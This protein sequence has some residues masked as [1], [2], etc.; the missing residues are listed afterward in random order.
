MI[1]NNFIVSTSFNIDLYMQIICITCSDGLY[2]LLIQE[3]FSTFLFVF[4]LLLPRLCNIIK[5][6]QPSIN[7]AGIGYF[8]L[9]DNKILN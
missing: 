8:L 1:D 5:V 4:L 3:F 9:E 6:R 7:N 2:D